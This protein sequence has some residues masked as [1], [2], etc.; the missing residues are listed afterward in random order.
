MCDEAGLFFEYERFDKPTRTRPDFY[1]PAFDRYIEI[2]PDCH[3]PKVMPENGILIKDMKHAKALIWGMTLRLY[4]RLPPKV[5][6]ELKE[7]DTA[8][9]INATVFL[10][11]LIGVADDARGDVLADIASRLDDG[12]VQVTPLG[13]TKLGRA[14]KFY[15]VLVT[16]G[17]MACEWRAKK[18]ARHAL[19]YA[20][21]AMAESLKDPE[22]MAGE[23]SQT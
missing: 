16:Y 22:T 10:R 14:G 6:G 12:E 3:G 20:H 2:H 21:Q 11:S 17:G 7:E 9:I 19:A 18:S 23:A 5:L 15:G 1:F 13:R 8:A 4:G